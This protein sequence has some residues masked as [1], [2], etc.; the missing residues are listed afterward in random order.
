KRDVPRIG[1]LQEEDWM[2]QDE[3]SARSDTIIWFESARIVD[4]EQ[5]IFHGRF[6]CKDCSDRDT[7]RMAMKRIALK[8]SATIRELMQGAL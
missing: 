5:V 6:G 1:H 2:F 3:A 7:A 8:E 4:I